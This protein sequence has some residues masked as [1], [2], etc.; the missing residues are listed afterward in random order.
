[1]AEVTEFAMGAT[2]SCVDGPGGKVS[3]LGPETYM[4]RGPCCQQVWQLR[5]PR[6]RPA[7]F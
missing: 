4:R 5:N 6:E 2:A 1:M 3:R 7:L